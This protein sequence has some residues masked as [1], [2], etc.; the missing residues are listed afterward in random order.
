MIVNSSPHLVEMNRVHLLWENPDTATVFKS[1]TIDLDLNKYSVI[2]ITFRFS[3]EDD[4]YMTKM[5]INDLGASTQVCTMAHDKEHCIRNVTIHADK[6]V[7]NY[8]DVVRQTK[9]GSNQIINT[10]LDNS[11]AIPYRIYGLM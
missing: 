4:V 1:Q 10:T 8:A 6:V 11:Y 9:S 5:T 2:Y 3:V 7:F